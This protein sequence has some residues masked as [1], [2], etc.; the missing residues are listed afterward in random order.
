MSDRLCF[1]DSNVWLYYLM[2]DPNSIEAEETR[3]H[4]LAV[5]LLK[6]ANSVVSTQIVNEVCAV[7]SRKASFNKTQIQ[8]VVESFDSRCPVVELNFEILI[9]A[10]EKRMR[11]GFSFWDGLIV[12]SALSTNAAIL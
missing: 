6:T 7:L 8:Q 2:V 5:N 9:S 12:A 1:I 11:Y 4:S 3:K 10:S